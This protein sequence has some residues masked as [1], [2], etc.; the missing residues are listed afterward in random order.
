M[1][2]SRMNRQAPMTVWLPL[3]TELKTMLYVVLRASG[4]TRAEL[5]RRLGWHREQVDRLFRLDHASK[6][7]QIEAAFQALEK[8]LDVRVRELA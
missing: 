1:P 2:S 3:L 8:H 6:L 4:I 5:A 7:D